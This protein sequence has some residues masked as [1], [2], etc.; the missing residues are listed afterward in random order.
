MNNECMN[1]PIE[2]ETYIPDKYE[3]DCDG[4]SVDVI[5]SAWYSY[6]IALHFSSTTD[7]EVV[8]NITPKGARELRKELKHAI[9]LV[10]IAD[11]I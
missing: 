4:H 6:K 9:A 3:I 1:E 8:I 10:N 7:K 2:A 11:D 5:S